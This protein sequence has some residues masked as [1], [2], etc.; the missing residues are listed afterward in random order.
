MEPLAKIEPD[1]SNVL[2]GYGMYLLP[3]LFYGPV[4]ALLLLPFGLPPNH[5]AYYVAYAAGAIAAT[6]AVRR[7]TAVILNGCYFSVSPEHLILGR[8][9]KSV[10]PISEIERAV[11]VIYHHRLFS[12]SKAEPATL[13]RFNV[14]LLAMKDGSRLALVP[15]SNLRGVDRFFAAVLETVR[16]VL[17]ESSPLDRRDIEAMA[18]SKANTLNRLD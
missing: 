18:P 6:V 9:P 5:W 17:R 8:E 2:W 3:F 1:L 13:Q 14:L 10:I 4:A 7:A 11:P 16:P 15:V 12:R